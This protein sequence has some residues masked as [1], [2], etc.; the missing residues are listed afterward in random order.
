MT[1]DLPVWVDAEYDLRADIAD[2]VARDTWEEAME[3]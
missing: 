3:E 1:D 2:E